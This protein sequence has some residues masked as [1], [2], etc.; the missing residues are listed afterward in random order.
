MHI[1][2]FPHHIIHAECI[3]GEINLLANRLALPPRSVSRRARGAL[4]GESCIGRCAAMV[5]DGEYEELM[6][7][8][9][10]LPETRLGDAYELQHVES[11]QR[12]TRR[13]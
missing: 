2:M 1:E 10:G 3:G 6:A 5:H 4:D 13:F 7:R 12:L 8:K 11:V 9:A